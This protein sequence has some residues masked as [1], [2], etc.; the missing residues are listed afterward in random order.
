MKF[1]DPKEKCHHILARDSCTFYQGQFVKDFRRLGRNLKDV[2]I[3][4]VKNIIFH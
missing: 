1:V 3:I 4:D 2:I